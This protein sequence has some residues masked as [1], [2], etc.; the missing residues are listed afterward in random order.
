MEDQPVL[1]A[2]QNA[3]KAA[4]CFW[5]DAGI[6]PKKEEYAVND[7]ASIFIE[8]KVVL[9]HW[10]GIVIMENKHHWCWTQKKKWQGLGK[11]A[12]RKSYAKKLQ[13]FEAMLEEVFDLGGKNVLEKKENVA[14]KDFIEDQVS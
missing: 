12:K 1:V 11:I 13:D 8:F 3:V 7:L 10:R 9:F 6:L 5:T 4:R 14:M 2:Q